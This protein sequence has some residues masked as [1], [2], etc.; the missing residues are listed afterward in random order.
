MAKIPESLN[1]GTTEKLSIP[2][3]LNIIQDLYRE[4]SVAVNQKAD[5]YQRKTDGLASDIA[6]SDGSININ[7]DTNKVEILTQHTSATVVNW[8]TI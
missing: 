3:L 1:L 4:L 5:I 6:L 7:T 8:E 2:E